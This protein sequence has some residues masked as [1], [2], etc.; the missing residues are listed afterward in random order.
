MTNDNDEAREMVD[1]CVTRHKTVLNPIIDWEDRD[2]WDFIHA[3]KVPY[4]GLYDEGYQRLGCIGC[5]MARRKGR[6]RDFY[7]WPTYKRAYLRA[8]GKMLEEREKRG[9][10]DGAWKKGTTPIEVFNWWMEYDIIPG[11]MDL[12]EEGDDI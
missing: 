9:K 5:P 7:K 1:A 11:Q 2:V 4:C 10:L 12:L 3:E 8:F 6:E